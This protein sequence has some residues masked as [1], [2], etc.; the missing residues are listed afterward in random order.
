MKFSIIIP[1]YK[2]ERYL[3]Q[4]ILSVLKQSYENYE[5]LLIDD[6]SPD[7][8]PILCDEWAQRDARVRTIHKENGGLSDARNTGIKHA[9]GDYLLFLDSDDY[10]DDESALEQIAEC[11]ENTSVDVLNFRYKKFLECDNTF[12]QCLQHKDNVTLTEND[13]R[14]TIVKKLFSN[15]LYIAC[16]WNKVLKNSFVDENNLYFKV[17]ITSEDIDW[18][19]RCLLY[20]EQ[21]SYIDLDFYVYRQR[22]GSITH[23]FTLKG[24]EDLKNN[25]LECVALGKDLKETD[26]LYPYYFSYVAYQYGV[27]LLD[28][29]MIENEKVAEIVAEMKKYQY[30][31]SFKMNKKI[32][33]LYYCNR[34]IGYD[35]LIRLLGIYAKYR[36]G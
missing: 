31:L 15:G 32:K 34:I 35:N 16:A 19:A 4:C 36:R 11:L 21:I 22:E 33:A 17:G 3:E 28:I 14:K 25:I 18:C 10:W 8:C 1:V 7:Q 2:V 23:S 6:G 26:E 5:I 29:N 13:S 9:T 27:F 24:L 20:A 12:H 30:L